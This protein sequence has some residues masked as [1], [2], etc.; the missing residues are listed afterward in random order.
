MGHMTRWRALRS[1]FLAACLVGGPPVF[2]QPE[3]ANG[4]L[5]VAKPGMLDT[6]FRETVVLV[7][8]MA[9]FSTVG[10]ILNR[11]MRA[12][13][14]ELLPDAPKAATYTDAV[15][16]GGPV[17][18]RTLV[19]LYKSEHTPAGAAFPVLKNVYLS[20]H[21]E[22]IGPL[23]ETPGERLRMFAGFS[24]WAPR[25]LQGELE[26]DGWYVLPVTEE[27]LFRK[28]TSGMWEELLGRA[29]G[30]RAALYSSS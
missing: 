27:L 26:R 29:L 8:Q 28:N 16:F 15:Y 11:P 30:K 10:V 2:A 21:P 6:R 9:D 24:G 3:P 20:M 19:A 18:E 12:K 5:L 25:Q 22:V 23:L 14:P 7:T 4:I 17:M 13:L 1:L